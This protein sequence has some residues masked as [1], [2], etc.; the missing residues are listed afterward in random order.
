MADPTKVR[1]GQVGGFRDELAA[2]DPVGSDV[3]GLDFYQAVETID[4]A[5]RLY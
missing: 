1:R 5:P 4:R 2:A 3:I